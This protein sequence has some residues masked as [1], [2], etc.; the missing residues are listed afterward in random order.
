MTGDETQLL[1]ELVR[2]LVLQLR[3]QQGQQQQTIVALDQAGFGP[4]RIAQLLGTT[5]GTVSV[6]L[7]RAKKKQ[8]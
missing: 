7:Q 6:A 2:L 8:A 5:P 4:K 3:I 1:D